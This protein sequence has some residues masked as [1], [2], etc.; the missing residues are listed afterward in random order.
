MCLTYFF[1]SIFTTQLLT[2][3]FP[4]GL[5][6]KSV[7]GGGH[8]QYYWCKWDLQTFLEYSGSDKTAW[9]WFSD[10][11]R[12]MIYDS[13]FKN[14]RTGKGSLFQI[15]RQKTNTMFCFFS[16]S[17]QNGVYEVNYATTA[18]PPSF[19]SKQAASETPYKNNSLVA[20]VALAQLHTLTPRSF[21]RRCWSTN[22]HGFGGVDRSQWKLQ[23]LELLRVMQAQTTSKPK[24]SH[25]TSVCA[26]LH[27]SVHE[28]KWESVKSVCVYVCVCEWS[29][30][31]Q[32]VSKA[33]QQ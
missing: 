17:F 8:I 11:S 31:L 12:A 30:G 4:F 21:L 5:G 3:V 13:V 25:I 9:I 6:W 20:L 18:S 22:S 27:L 10:P 1:Y 2:S 29:Q 32:G 7:W 24:F 28:G 19:C 14:E 23:T 16:F 33:F 26:V 15:I